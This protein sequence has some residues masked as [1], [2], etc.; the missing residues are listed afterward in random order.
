M[1]TWGLNSGIVSIIYVAEIEPIVLYAAS[2]WSSA[3]EKLKK[4]NRL[5]SLQRGFTQKVCKAQ[6]T[7]SLS[8]AFDLSGLL[9]LDFRFREAANLFKIK[10]DVAWTTARTRY[11][12]QGRAIIEPTSITPCNN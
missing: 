3:T 5:D 4:K 1:K 6:R 12:A 7:D 8:S 10:K 11:R 9:L 2:A